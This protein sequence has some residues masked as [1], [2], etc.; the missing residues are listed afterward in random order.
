M[1]GNERLLDTPSVFLRAN[2]T[3]GYGSNSVNFL[4]F[5]HKKP[6]N[7]IDYECAL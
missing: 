2:Q 7:S 5:L 6:A 1:F 3:D 4:I